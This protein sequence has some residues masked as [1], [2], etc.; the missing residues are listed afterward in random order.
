LVKQQKFYHFI[1]NF[2]KF[3]VLIL[4]DTSEWELRGKKSSR[5]NLGK[6][7]KM[8]G[9]KEIKPKRNLWMK[10]QKIHLVDY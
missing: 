4:V 6:Y 7:L 9:G 5:T 10:S 1:P 3:C 8:S 2:A